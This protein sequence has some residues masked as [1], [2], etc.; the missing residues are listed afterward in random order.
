MGNM[1]IKG[2]KRKANVDESI[3][4]RVVFL[5]FEKLQF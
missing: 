3:F 5:E 4:F 1:R 2:Q